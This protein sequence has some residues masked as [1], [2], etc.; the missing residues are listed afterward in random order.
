MN[1]LRHVMILASAG[2]GKT[3]A[4]TN[5]FVELLAA[6]AAPERIVALTFT[7]KAAG[8]FF[9][10]ILKKLAR[11]SGDDA[12]AAELADALG[13]PELRATDFLALL[14]RMI[15]AMPRLRLGTL[16]S[17]FARIARAFPL[18]LG[19]AGDFEVLQ[20]HAA[21]I[22]RQRVLR[23]MFARTGSSLAAA[24]A[25]FIEAFK[26]AT[27]GSEEKQ[28]GARL[29]AF[30]DQHQENFLAAPDKAVWGEA[31][32]I[33]PDG[34]PW[35]VDGINLAEAIRE[36]RS[37]LGTLTDGQRVRW[38]NFFSTLS[39]WT[40]G[41]PLPGPVEYILKNAL[42]V[43]DDICS[44]QALIT[45]DRRKLEMPKGACHALRA[46]ITFVIGAEFRRR[47]ET[48]R[49]IYEV[50]RSYE[51]QYHDAVRRAGRLT[52]SD[53]QR[54]LRPDSGAPLLSAKV[55]GT[56]SAQGSAGPPG[57]AS[58]DIRRGGPSGPVL[59]E[60]GVG[61]EDDP[62]DQMSLAFDEAGPGEITESPRANSPLTD[63][64]SERR[65][66]IDYRL[67]AE[68]DHW[69]L[70][71]FQD[72]SYGQWSVLRNL[73]D[74][75]VQDPERRRSFFCVGDVKQA[76]YAWREGDPRLF[77]EIFNHYNQ[78]APD[79]IEERHLVASWRS[80]P[81]VIE[82]VNAVFGSPY[83]LNEL[84]PGD[85]STAWNAEWR[86]HE[87]AVPQRTGQAALLLAG[88]ERERWT[89]AQRL[90]QEIDPLSRGLTCA[91]LVK[92]NDIAAAL[93]D[94]LR[95]AGIAAIAESDLHVATDN[96]LGTALLA[97]AQAAAHPGDTQ[98]QEHVR[99][100]PL[101]DVLHQRGVST[102]EALTREVLD[103][104]HADGFERAMEFW[105]GQLEPRLAPDDEFTRGRGREFI[106]AAGLF[107]A[108]G[109]RD[110]DEFIAFMQHHAIRPPESTAVVRVM[111]I[112]KSKGLGFDVVILPDLEGNRIDERRDG[113]AVKK[114]RD[115]AVQWILDLPPKLFC[116]QDEV[117]AQYVRSAE[118][119]A[120]YENLSLLYVALTRA[121][122]AMYVITEPVGDSKSRNFPKL[123]A[124]TLGDTA[125]EIRVGD[126]KFAGSWGSGEPEWHAT[127][128]RKA[129]SAAESRPALEPVA[130]A[131]SAG[132]LRRV[133]HR[134]SDAPDRR[135]AAEALFAIDQASGMEFGT[136]VHELLADVAWLESD[137]LP[138]LRERWRARGA[139]RT[140]IETTESAL[141]APA[142]ASV[143]HRPS[144][145][146][147]V[148]RERT[149]E[150]VLDGT[151]FTGVFDRVVLERAAGKI[152]RVTVYDFKTD[153]VEN[154]A[155]MARAVA[156]YA[157]Q[158]AVYRRVAEVLTGAG[159][160]TVECELV[161]THCRLSV[162]VPA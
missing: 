59:P 67:D 130:L 68:I 135:V 156:R 46:I 129:A 159:A 155:D 87:S 150:I 137:A 84:F 102:P 109:S 139:S 70:D 37:A 60:M 63:D 88:D 15:D 142:L 69:L 110:V 89:V 118:A 91:V 39:D 147:E 85:A 83:T 158:L 103:R 132:P 116:G 144:R 151:W 21:E 160:E 113:L 30:L 134:A 25:E 140:V 107:D 95:R 119:D 92:K 72:T 74:E 114:A 38:E 162:P 73:I 31:R 56:D 10:E 121:K 55:S 43:W 44:G 35:L 65:L 126:V 14:R 1:E 120:C 115:R 112:H 5:R 133:G 57:P 47:I 152:R 24:Q 81:P 22:E 93:A 61:S 128:T 77:R 50:L 41:A 108:T 29:D 62:D 32:R 19:L 125:G 64:A 20:E 78:A 58:S 117:L 111:T 101:G 75:V 161:F 13:R 76:I 131:T 136:S 2:S 42:A 104:I 4:L 8:E 53:V 3:Y 40:P 86:N 52:F 146:A 54:L 127:L 7:R 36:L 9:D 145:D 97:L 48:T 26:R 105:V 66:L 11:A 100:T 148:W 90:I 143:W 106:S 94:F 124:A 51:L 99:M 96:P 33:W 123:L 141:T 49:G 157:E 149:F 154:D 82:M 27:F 153:R 45:I 80:G 98:A 23:R 138:A 34:S 18:E 16:D 17:F 71:E 12:F 122:R 6:G 79:S 28:L